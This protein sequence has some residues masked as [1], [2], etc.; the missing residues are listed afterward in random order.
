MSPRSNAMHLAP[1]LLLS[2]SKLQQQEQ[3]EKA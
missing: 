1:F 2:E 3:Q